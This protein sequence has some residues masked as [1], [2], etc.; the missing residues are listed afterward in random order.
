MD[1]KI[2]ALF[3]ALVLSVI[4]ITI[5][6]V[7]LVQQPTN[8]LASSGLPSLRSGIYTDGPPGYPHYFVSLE[9]S[10]DGSITGNVDY[11]YQDGSTDA[12]LTFL[13]TGQD[14]IANLQ[15]SYSGAPN[16]SSAGPTAITMTWSPNKIRM[17]NCA[18][19][20]PQERPSNSGCYFRYSAKGLS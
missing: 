9:V 4:A 1:N 6:V 5:S 13:G 20:L 8:V 12:A 15:A 16:E 10:P 18:F 2:S 14:G 17:S 19:Y 3:A 7:A 11:L